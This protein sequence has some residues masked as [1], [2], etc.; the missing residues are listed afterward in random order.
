[1]TLYAP[2]SMWDV[3][4]AV[5]V[6]G[7]LRSRARVPRENPASDAPTGTLQAPAATVAGDGVAPVRGDA[8]PPAREASS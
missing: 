6:L 8:T 3:R 4:H 1:M 5:R 2:D 7:L